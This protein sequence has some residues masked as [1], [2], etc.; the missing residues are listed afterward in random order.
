MKSIVIS[1]PHLAA[2]IHP[3]LGGCIESLRFQGTP[4]LREPQSGTMTHA[5]LSAS[6]PL[7]P[8]S[9]RIARA[10][11]QWQGQHH[12]LRPNFPPEPHMIHGVGWQHAWQVREATPQHCVLDLSHGGD[13]NWPFAFEATQRFDISDHMLRME[14]QITNR[15]PQAAPVGLG[16]HPYF[17]KREGA[18]LNFDAAGVWQMGEDKIPTGRVSSAGF[19]GGCATL[20]VDNCFD[21]WPGVATLRDE[22]LSVRIESDLRHL[23]VFTHP[24]RD[25]VAIEPVSHV[26]NALNTRNPN[27]LGVQTLQPGQSWQASMRISVE[28]T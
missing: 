20:D 24:S 28:S 6:Y 3:E 9:N 17:V 25:F 22:Q 4:V 27:E 18:V 15:A 21:A 5:R 13:A 14:M 12:T 19:H 7:V 2:H 8:F 11:F 1:T 23:V 10:Q 26:N 16:W